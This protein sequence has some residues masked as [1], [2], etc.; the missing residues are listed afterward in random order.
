[1]L[2]LFFVSVGKTFETT[3][4]FFFLRNF[5]SVI[6]SVVGILDALFWRRLVF[7]FNACTPNVGIKVVV[8]PRNVKKNTSRYCRI[9]KDYIQLVCAV[10]KKVRLSRRQYN[11]S[12]QDFFSL[13]LSLFDTLFFFIISVRYSASLSETRGNFSPDDDG[14]LGAFCWLCVKWNMLLADLN[15]GKRVE[16]ARLLEI[17][18]IVFDFSRSEW[19]EDKKRPRAA[20]KKKQHRVEHQSRDFFLSFLLLFTSEFFFSLPSLRTSIV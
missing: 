9:T 18:C 17:Q 5:C 7:V 15:V 12:F 14:R 6:G 19:D 20:K 11:K 10:W 2:S 1:M 13:S 8:E 4:K 16:C 3:H